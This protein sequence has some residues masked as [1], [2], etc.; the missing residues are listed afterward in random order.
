MAVILSTSGGRLA[1]A[2]LEPRLGEE[3]WASLLEEVRAEVRTH[4]VDG[5]VQ[6][7]G[8]TWLVSATNS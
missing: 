5:V 8:A 2:Q 4:L 1:R 7:P 6:L 3:G